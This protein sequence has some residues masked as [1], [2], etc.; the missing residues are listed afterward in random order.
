MIIYRPHR[1]GLRESMEGAREFI[2][3]EAMFDYIAEMHGHAFA[4]KDLIIVRESAVDD[5]R[6]GWR[7]TM[8]ICTKRY[9]WKS[10]D[11]PQ[12]VGMCA[13]DYG[14][15]ERSQRMCKEFLD[16]K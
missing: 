16:G 15:L 5:L 12:C 4:P 9:L 11:C 8:Y 2:T 7:N 10:Y 3:K 6:T 1:G 13:T 14:S